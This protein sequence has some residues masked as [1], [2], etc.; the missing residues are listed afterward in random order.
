LLLFR[1]ENK[2]MRCISLASFEAFWTVRFEFEFFWV[3]TPCVIV[4]G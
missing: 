3:V 1:V 4:V 2:A